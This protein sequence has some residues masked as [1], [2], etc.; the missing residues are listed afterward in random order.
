M[1]CARRA[2][3]P[4]RNEPRPCPAR[5]PRKEG[6]LLPAP[7]TAPSCVPGSGLLARLFHLAAAAHPLG[8]DL[9]VG[10]EL[11]L[12]LGVELLDAPA[13]R[14]DLEVLLGGVAMRLGLGGAILRFG[15]FL[16]IFGDLLA[17]LLEGLVLLDRRLGR[18][19]A[20]AGPH[21]HRLAVEARW[22]L[23]GVD[24]L[25]RLRVRVLVELCA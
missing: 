21:V 25:A 12:A 14:V 1:G 5:G 15:A 4:A 2:S 17:A 10:H 7:G 20:A 18:S 11:A 6:S 19:R 23:V 8:L 24:R 3:H 22:W 16:G 13:V 9:L